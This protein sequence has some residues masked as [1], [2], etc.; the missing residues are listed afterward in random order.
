MYSEGTECTFLHRLIFSNLGVKAKAHQNEISLWL[1][2]IPGN[3][4]MHV[5][6]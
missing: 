4:T 3:K 6:L 2:S 5:L 1:L